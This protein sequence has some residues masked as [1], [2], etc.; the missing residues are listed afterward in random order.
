MRIGIVTGEYPPMRGGV[1]AYTHILAQ[2]LIH[3]RHYVHIF[4]SERSRTNNDRIF[5][6]NPVNKWGINS[7][8]MVRK[9]AHEQRLDV[10]NIQYQIAAF[11]MSPW[12]H[13]LPNYVRHIPVVTTF[14]DLKHPYLFPKAGRLRDWIV[15]HLARS[16]RGVIVT[17]HEDLQ[18]VQHL[19][20]IKLI[21]IGSNILA[22][23]PPDFDPASWREKAGAKP[24][25]FLLAYF[26][27]INRSK[28]LERLLETITTLRNEGIP[29]R[30]IMI[31]DTTGTS[32]SS[33]RSYVAEIE[34]L[35]NKLG[36][37]PYIHR[38]G[39]LEDDARV[40]S[41]LKASDVVVLPF[42]DGASYRRGSLMA[43]IHYGC[44]IVSTTPQVKIPS[45]VH[46]DNMLLVPPGDTAGL[47]DSLRNLRASPEL[48]ERL[49]NG[50]SKIAKGFD[51]TA[52][53]IDYTNF[54]RW[55]IEGAPA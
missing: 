35:M 18:R 21:P 37:A 36:I 51:W 49:R 40:A 46:G 19:H 45:F 34:T 50:A 17:N 39:F 54:L 4:S 3:Q 25:D 20:N 11:D 55:I 8:R 14:H 12:I 5:L 24:G 42:A 9:W 48:R 13:F 1:G 38:T 2:E 26:G 22:P 47:T 52:I 27:L 15:M 31:G 53:A 44:A 23:L 41:Y 29:A 6:T 43:A 33:N 32:D 30:L 10:L 28:G 16:S 7:L